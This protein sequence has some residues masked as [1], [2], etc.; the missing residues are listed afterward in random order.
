MPSR[1]TVRDT[2]TMRPD[3]AEKLR[4]LTVWAQHHGQP[5]ATKGDVVEAALSRLEDEWAGEAGLTKIPSRG[6]WDLRYGPR[7][8]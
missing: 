4:D 3:V 7:D 2:I 1:G 5:R 6:N 8:E